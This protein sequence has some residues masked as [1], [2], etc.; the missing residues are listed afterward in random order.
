M[1]EIIE[2]WRTFKE[3]DNYEVSNTGKIRNKITLHEL[4]QRDNGHGYLAVHLYE[5][6]QRKV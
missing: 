5:K 6:R 3:N 1:Q 4:K 2:E